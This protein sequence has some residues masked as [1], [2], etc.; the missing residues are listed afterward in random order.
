MEIM[1]HIEGSK[2]DYSDWHDGLGMI[3]GEE[4][5]DRASSPCKSKSE[6]STL[7][8]KIQVEKEED[9]R[10]RLV[11]DAAWEHGRLVS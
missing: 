6:E 1:G 7:V 2:A 5:D 3:R 4:M 10:N 9:E 8:G 11:K